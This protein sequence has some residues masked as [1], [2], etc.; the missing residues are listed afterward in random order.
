MEEFF[1]N[2]NKVIVII[3]QSEILHEKI[4]AILQK[5]IY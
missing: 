4:Y 1:E 3:H 5:I 2:G